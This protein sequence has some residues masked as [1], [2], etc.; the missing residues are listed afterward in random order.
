LSEFLKDDAGLTLP[1]TNA[2][3]QVATVHGAIP[4]VV[5]RDEHEDA[6]PV[7]AAGLDAVFLDQVP[8]D[9]FEGEA[10]GW[11]VQA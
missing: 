11:E 8:D 10:T 9:L 7:G 6:V 4:D 3:S 2:K 1:V 5:C